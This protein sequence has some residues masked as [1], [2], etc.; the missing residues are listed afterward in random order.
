MRATS[1]GS[2]DAYASVPDNKYGGAIVAKFLAVALEGDIL[3]CLDGLVRA[4]G[5]EPI[6]KVR[7]FNEWA[8]VSPFVNQTGYLGAAR[9]GGWTV[10]ADD[11]SV[12][13]R[14]FDDVDLGSRLAHQYATRV[15]SAYG[16]S[17]SGFCGFRVHTPGGLRSVLVDQN[18]L[19][20]D[21]GDPIPGE[22]PVDPETFNEYS[23][24]D[25]LELLGLDIA[26]GVE[27]SSRCALLQFATAPN[28]AAARPRE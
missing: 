27:S 23:V 21:E 6:G 24:L 25:I 7:F 15:V 8:S 11:S 9:S 3:D 20:E 4:C 13:G 17:V 19:V 1:P 12:C 14:I 5:K 16:S 22:E 18:R 10:L 28:A 2:C 26:D